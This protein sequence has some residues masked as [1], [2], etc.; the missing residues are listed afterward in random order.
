MKPYSTD[1]RTKIVETKYKTNES[2]EQ[3]ANRFQVSYSFVQKLFKRYEATGSVEPSPHGGAK[4]RKLNPQQVEIVLQLVEEDN[5]ATLQQLC[6]RLSAKTKIKVSVPTMCRILQKLELTRKKAVR[7]D[8]E[9]STNH[10]QMLAALSFYQKSL[11]Y[12]PPRR[13]QTLWV[14]GATHLNFKN[15]AEKG[16]KQITNLK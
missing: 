12:P 2:I 8:G 4:P 10:R 13:R 16:F 3:I 14:A 6:D 15:Q 7:G 11:P 9:T 1:F 5:D